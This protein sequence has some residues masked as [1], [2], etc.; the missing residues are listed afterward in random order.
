[1]ANSLDMTT[2]AEGVDVIEYHLSD[3][4]LEDAYLEIVGSGDGE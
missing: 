1:M 2:T 3:R 4:R